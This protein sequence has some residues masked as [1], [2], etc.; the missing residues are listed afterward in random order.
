A[1][2]GAPIALPGSGPRDDL[3]LVL[4]DGGAAAVAWH[5][6]ELDTHNGVRVVT[7]TGA[8]AFGAAREAAPGTRQSGGNGLLTIASNAAPQDTPRLT[9]SLAGANLLL[10]WADP[11]RHGGP[12]A[13]PGLAARP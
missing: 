12:R 1:G 5:P 13:R 2:F 10:P 3:A 6:D 11:P 9:A 8:G 4:A 7:R